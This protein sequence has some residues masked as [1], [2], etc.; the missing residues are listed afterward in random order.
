[1]PDELDVR[2]REGA[3]DVVLATGVGEVMWVTGMRQAE[4]GSI[5]LSGPGGAAPQGVELQHLRYAWMEASL[6]AEFS[7]IR[8][9]R[10]D[11]GLGWMSPECESL[12]S[13]S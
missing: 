3:V 2:A 1:L 11:A 9:R 12:P 7:S 8:Q 13:R 4:A 10:A 6:D 5:V